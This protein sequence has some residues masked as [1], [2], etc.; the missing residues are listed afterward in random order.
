MDGHVDAAAAG[1]GVV[2][3]AAAATAADVAAIDVAA[4]APLSKSLPAAAAA[5]GVA[6]S[7]AAANSVA[8]LAEGRP[9]ERR[10]ESEH[11]GLDGSAH[12]SAGVRARLLRWQPL[13]LRRPTALLSDGWPSIEQA[14]PQ[15]PTAPAGGGDRAAEGTRAQEH[16]PLAS[17]V[18]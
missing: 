16:V 15:R 6:A 4:A 13:R 14:A 2:T 9:N 17:V 1:A 3:A 12:G 18:M 11:L 5:K 8:T 7:V 10:R